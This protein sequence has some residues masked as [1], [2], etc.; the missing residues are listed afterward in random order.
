[1]K[2]IS[3]FL[4]VLMV[5]S[6]FMISCGVAGVGSDSSISENS[7]DQPEDSVDSSAA[8][9][10]IDITADSSV[11]D[12]ESESDTSNDE[13]SADEP[14][15]P[16]VPD[17]PD[18]PDEPDEPEVPEEP[19][20]SCVRDPLTEEDVI[21][22]IGLGESIRLYCELPDDFVLTKSY[23]ASVTSLGISDVRP[24][25][26]VGLEYLTSLQDFGCFG[27]HISDI[28]VISG[29]TELKY[30][31][32]A[33]SLVK[34]IPDLSR[35]TQLES[36]DLSGNLIEDLSPLLTAPHISYVSMNDNRIST[37]H[38]IADAQNIDH[39]CLSGNPILDISC[40]SDNDKLVEGMKEYSYDFKK[41]VETEK[42]AQKIV[43]EI[44][45]EDMTDLEKEYAVY[46]YII[47]NMEYGVMKGLEKPFG[48]DGLIK[49]K[50]VCLEYANSFCL[51]AKTAGLDVIVV[52][53]DTH[54]WDM[55]KLDGKYY[56]VDTTWDDGNEIPFFFNV[57]TD[58]IMIQSDHEHDL[59]RYPVAETMPPEVY[60][61]LFGI[62]LS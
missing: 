14:D 47:D 27:T 23:L 51:L 24:E 33:T 49:G 17:V 62:D 61:Y 22:D 53:S 30:F 58:Y 7:Q 50:G 42:K 43:S 56:H 18:E 16:D 9:D 5:I 55:I 26:L 31:Y 54:A 60:E 2:K 11:P 52:L 8:S 28:S 34:E 21:L 36:L 12:S 39:I 57:G 59:A 10:S 19:E 35:L 32:L 46:R 13:T 1:M 37:V 4:A 25:T 44:I 15:E 41:A 3:F 29:M 40:L 48:Y 6:C 20:P 38:P 45:T